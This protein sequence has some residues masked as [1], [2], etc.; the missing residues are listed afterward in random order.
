MRIKD[1]INKLLNQ[2]AITYYVNNKIVDL[3]TLVE[4]DC[5]VDYF[6]IEDNTLNIGSSEFKN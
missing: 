1:L 4:C 5:E 3:D 2:L 6:E